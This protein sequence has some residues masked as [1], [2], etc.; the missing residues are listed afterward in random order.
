M[1]VMTDPPCRLLTTSA[2]TVEPERSL[3]NIG[4]DGAS[5]HQLLQPVHLP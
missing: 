2:R 4:V 5:V 1:T 3:G